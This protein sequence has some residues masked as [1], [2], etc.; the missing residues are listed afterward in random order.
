M[1]M[2][3]LPMAVEDEGAA[4]A[5]P[6]LFPI[7]AKA[8]PAAAAPTKAI[9]THFLLCPLLALV[10]LLFVITMPGVT[11]SIGNGRSGDSVRPAGFGEG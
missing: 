4:A 10:E 5:V 2:L 1:L 9:H 8:P 6:L 3:G 11:G 7:A